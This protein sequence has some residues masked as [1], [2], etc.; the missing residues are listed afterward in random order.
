MTSHKETAGRSFLTCVS[1]SAA[2]QP[3]S[4]SLLRPPAF[5]LSLYLVVGPLFRCFPPAGPLLSLS[6]PR[7]SRSLVALSFSVPCTHA[8][9]PSLSLANSVTLSSP[10]GRISFSCRLP[11]TRS[12]TG[13]LSLGLS[14]S[15]SD[16]VNSRSLPRFVLL[17]AYLAPIPFPLYSASSFLAQCLLLRVATPFVAARSVGPLNLNVCGPWNSGF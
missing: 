9:S 16:T 8:V 11:P 5:Y 13:D 17:A 3:F 12:A 14:P 1:E 7:C 2:P 6:P 4:V 15:L 10:E